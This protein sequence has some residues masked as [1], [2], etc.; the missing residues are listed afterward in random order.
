MAVRE[1]PKMETVIKQHL[2]KIVA[3]LN[4][5][6]KTSSKV[7]WNIL[8]YI[9]DQLIEHEEQEYALVAVEDRYNLHTVIVDILKMA[10]GE[11]RSSDDKVTQFKRKWVW[12]EHAVAT[13]AGSLWCNSR[14]CWR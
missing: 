14:F 5:E 10:W 8:E 7:S 3:L 9:C 4:S 1:K 2:D 11:G 6:D 13:I 12:N